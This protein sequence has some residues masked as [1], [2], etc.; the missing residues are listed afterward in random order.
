MA[1]RGDQC[2][3]KDRVLMLLFQ[4]L[5]VMYGVRVPFELPL[6]LWL[7]QME[8]CDLQLKES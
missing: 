5:I 3:E 7:V 1:D 8:F 2:T 6:L 4:S